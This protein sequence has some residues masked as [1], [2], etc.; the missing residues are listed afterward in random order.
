MIRMIRFARR[1][2]YDGGFLRG[3]SCFGT[4]AL[5]VDGGAPKGAGVE[6]ESPDT[7]HDLGKTGA[8]LLWRRHT[9]FA[10]GGLDVLKFPVSDK[11]SGCDRRLEWTRGG[12]LAS[13]ALKQE[14]EEEGR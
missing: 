2:T 9:L 14:E 11:P 10:G 13:H 12:L 5:I 7:G 3:C 4:S 1:F 6:E 8:D